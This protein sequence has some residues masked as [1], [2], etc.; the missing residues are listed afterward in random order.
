MVG[1]SSGAFRTAG[2]SV[3]DSPL[4]GGLRARRS[5]ADALAFSA[6]RWADAAPPEVG[7][8]E[9]AVAVGALNLKP[10]PPSQM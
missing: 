7:G 2:K 9:S 5:P 1:V 6:G 8:R 4:A 3:K 10:R